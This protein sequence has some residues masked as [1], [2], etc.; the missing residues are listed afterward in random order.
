MQQTLLQNE[1]EET[2]GKKQQTGHG[3]RVY[4]ITTVHFAC[5]LNQSFLGATVHP[6]LGVS[7]S[8]SP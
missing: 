3:E 6:P 8:A 5:G 4:K 1:E 7:W 2:I